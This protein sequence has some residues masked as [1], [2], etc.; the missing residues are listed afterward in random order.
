MEL[1]RRRAKKAAKKRKTARRGTT[2]EADSQHDQIISSS[3][4]EKEVDQLASNDVELPTV[5]KLVA[6]SKRKKHFDARAHDDEAHEARQAEKEKRRKRTSSKSSVKDPAPEVR[7]P[8][9]STRFHSNAF[10]LLSRRTA[11]SAGEPP[12]RLLHPPRNALFPRPGPRSRHLLLRRPRSQ[13]LRSSLQHL[14]AADRDDRSGVRGTPK[15]VDARG[16]RE[17][18][19]GEAE[20]H[21]R[22]RG[23]RCLVTRW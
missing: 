3:E 10:S 13:A 20:D 17:G 15:A 11:S 7:V 9:H 6:A 23:A 5:D 2:S 22:G 4:S 12:S 18:V 1:K 8:S 14:L 16:G 19:G 21:E